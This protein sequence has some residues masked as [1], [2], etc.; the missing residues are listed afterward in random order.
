VTSHV[1][2]AES[3]LKAG[4]SSNFAAMIHCAL[5]WQPHCSRNSWYVRSRWP[6]SSI[7]RTSVPVGSR[8]LDATGKV[9]NRVKNFPLRLAQ[10]FLR[11]V[12]LGNI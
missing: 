4:I 1:G 7:V 3:I 9:A 12:A 2:G 8:M 11:C 10:V 6:T 5:C